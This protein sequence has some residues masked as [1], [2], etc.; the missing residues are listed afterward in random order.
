MATLRFRALTELASKKAERFSPSSE[1]IS[2]Y[3]SENV[4]DRA[5]MRQ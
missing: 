2:K 3:F 1:N 5:K 4:F